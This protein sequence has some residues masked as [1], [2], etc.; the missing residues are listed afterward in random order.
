VWESVTLTILA[1]TEMS[2]ALEMFTGWNLGVEIANPDTIMRAML[3]DTSTEY[4]D[5]VTD[6]APRQVVLQARPTIL[7]I[8]GK[9]KILKGRDRKQP[10]LARVQP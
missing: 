5:K 10:V 7:Q 6:Y 1:D 3:S 9:G 4:L 8:I 2:Q